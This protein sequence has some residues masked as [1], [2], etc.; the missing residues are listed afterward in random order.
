MVD[1]TTANTSLAVPLRG[2]NVGTWDVPVNDN[3]TKIDSM[4]GGVATVAMSGANVTL[5]SSQSQS[6]IIRITG[7]LTGNRFLVFSGIY[8]SWTIDNQI[9]NSPSSF[10]VFLLSSATTF[11][12]GA[13]PGVN[14]VFYDGTS[15]K[16]IN[17]G[18]IGEY[19][20]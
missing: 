17:M 8:K 14:D 16:Y 10:A 6:S 20:D 19:W 15:I 9:T 18:R 3:T 12:L 2:S 13:A 11:Q 5:T 1:P 4:F 7:T